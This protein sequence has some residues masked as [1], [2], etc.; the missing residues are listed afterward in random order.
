MTRKVNFDKE[1]CLSKS[2]FDFLIF[3]IIL[4][5]VLL[6][7]ELANYKPIRSSVTYNCKKFIAWLRRT[8][9]YRKAKWLINEF[10][11]WCNTKAFPM[12]KECY[13]ESLWYFNKFI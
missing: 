4:K 3:V 8:K 9:V 7:I 11:C 5:I 1:N 12:V 6:I 10:L 2:D 13:L